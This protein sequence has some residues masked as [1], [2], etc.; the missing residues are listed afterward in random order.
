MIKIKNIVNFVNKNIKILI[1]FFFLF[2]I[3]IQT[4]NLP[5]KIYYIVKLSYYERLAKNYEKIFYSGF[6]EK[7]SHGYLIHIITKFE[8]T[9][10]PKVI[11]FEKEKRVPYWLFQNINIPTLDKTDDRKIILLN[12][13]DNFKN[14]IDFLKYKILDNYKNRCFFLE[15]ND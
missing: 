8:H 12:F 13:D 4:T 3:F 10:L 7:Q 1:I 9:F 5:Y 14:E 2:V 15:R 11:N 6:C